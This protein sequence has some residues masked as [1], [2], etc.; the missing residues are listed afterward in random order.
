MPSICC[1]CSRLSAFD[2]GYKCMSCGDVTREVDNVDRVR[3]TQDTF[4][5]EVGREINPHFWRRVCIARYS[6]VAPTR[7]G[8]RLKVE[9]WLEDEH[10]RFLRDRD[11]VRRQQREDKKHSGESGYERQAPN[12][13]LEHEIKGLE[14][15]ESL[16]RDGRWRV[17][18]YKWVPK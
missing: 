2:P 18:V 7:E 14:Y 15:S 5:N 3:L 16:G 1:K 12:P 11:E 4:K 6:V 9:G 10:L 8:A 13:W 17:E